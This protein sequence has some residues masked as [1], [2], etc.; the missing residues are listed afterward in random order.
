MRVFKAKWSSYIH[1][2][3]VNVEWLLH[4]IHRLHCYIF[5]HH[6]KVKK[7]KKKHFFNFRGESWRMSARERKISAIRC[8]YTKRFSRHILWLAHELIHNLCVC[9]AYIFLSFFLA[10][11]LSVYM[12][13]HVY[14][15]SKSSIPPVLKIAKFSDVM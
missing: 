6:F 3:C 8:C 5:M 15:I 12:Y 14:V 7:K 9:I 11:S 2:V 10:H 1:W 4:I 13:K